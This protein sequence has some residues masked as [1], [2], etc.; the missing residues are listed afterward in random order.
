MTKK[1]KKQIM[2]ELECSFQKD[3]NPIWKKYKYICYH[4][5]ICFYFFLSQCD[6]DHKIYCLAFIRIIGFLVLIFISAVLAG[7]AESYLL[8]IWWNFLTRIA[9]I[10]CNTSK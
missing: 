2:L 5:D 1:L 7:S 8:K 6:Q 10:W 9:N 4:G 3:L